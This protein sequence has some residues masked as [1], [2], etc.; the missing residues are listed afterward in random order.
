M[1]FED[2]PILKSVALIL[3]QRDIGQNQQGSC[4]SF[5]AFGCVKPLG[6]QWVQEGV[7]CI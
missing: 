5:I 4:P 3:S 7:V 1:V 6:A 2:H